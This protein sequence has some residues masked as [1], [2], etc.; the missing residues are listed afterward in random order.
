MNH[1]YVGIF[2]TVFTMYLF[3]LKK[4]LL[5]YSAFHYNANIILNIKYFE[6]FDDVWM[7]DGL[8]F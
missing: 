2:F 4:I 8:T 3:I 7:T 1:N 5:A 6:E